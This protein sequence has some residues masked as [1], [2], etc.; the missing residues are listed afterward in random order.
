MIYPERIGASILVGQY[1][2]ADQPDIAERAA[3]NSF[4]MAFGFMVLVA[5]LFV[6]FPRLF[7]RPFV[8]S[9]SGV[10]FLKQ[11]TIILRIIALYTLFDTGNVVYAFALRGAGDTSFIMKNFAILT[12]ICLILPVWV[13]IQFL[14]MGLYWAWGF[15]AL[16][17][18]VL[19]V[20]FS[21]RFR[22]GKWK[23]MRVIEP[24]IL[25]S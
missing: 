22:G 19:A 21:I 12:P 17:V 1:L 23:Q 11:G 9:G 6:F 24:R 7:L 5:I 20:S 18:C 14:G 10:T 4:N 2:G 8:G 13:G 25:I 3:Q 15:A 16:F